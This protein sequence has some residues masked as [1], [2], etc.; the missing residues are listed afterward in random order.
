MDATWTV[1]GAGSILPRAGYGC[2]GYALLPAPGARVTLFDC[3]PGTVRALGGVGLGI[4]DVERVV[5]SHFHLDHCLDLFALAFARRNPRFDPLPSLELVG[6]PGLANLLERGAEAFGKYGRDPG[7]KVVE[8]APGEPLERERM[9]LTCARNGHTPEAVSWR[10][11]LAGGESV[12][13]SGDT[14]ESQAVAEL[15]REVDL[16]VVECSLPD[17][18]GSPNHLTPSSAGRLA[19]AAGCRRL[20]L[21][22]FYPD[23]DPERA[24]TQVAGLY[25]GPIE[26]ARDGSRHALTRPDA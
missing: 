13:Y 24:R 3:G 12:A 7:A 25:A 18:L 16:F 19:A 23:V 21:S 11:D 10:A 15:A 26:L 20:L 2:S 9:R 22:H 14:P 6:P 5:L 4:P 8:V 1:L 17:E